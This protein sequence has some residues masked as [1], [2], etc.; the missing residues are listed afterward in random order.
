MFSAIAEYLVQKMSKKII[1][2]GAMV[3]GII[4]F[5]SAI[6][7][8]IGLAIFVFNII[9]GNF[10]IHFVNESKL[11]RFIEEFCSKTAA[12]TTTPIPGIKHFF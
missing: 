12:T 8:S 3:V 7:S 11:Q 9:P 5:L 1:A 10:L 2:Y 6:G 4:S